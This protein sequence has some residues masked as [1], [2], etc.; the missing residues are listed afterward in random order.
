ME[1]TR[2]IQYHTLVL[3]NNLLTPMT[4]RRQW[5]WLKVDSPIPRERRHPDWV[6][7]AKDCLKS[8]LYQLHCKDGPCFAKAPSMAP[9]NNWPSFPTT[10]PPHLPIFWAEIFLPPT[11]LWTHNGTCIPCI[12]RVGSLRQNIAYCTQSSLL[13]YYIDKPLTSNDRRHYL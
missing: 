4:S 13:I 2:Y 12:N 11:Y 5:W 8:H 10:N 3:A 9:T 6:L 1:I 7:S